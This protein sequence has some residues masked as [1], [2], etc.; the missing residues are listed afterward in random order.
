MVVSG[1]SCV[2]A[3][4]VVKTALPVA[5]AGQK[6]DGLSVTKPRKCFPLSL[7]TESIMKIM[8]KYLEIIRQGCEMQLWYL[9]CM[10][11]N[12]VA[13]IFCSPRWWCSLGRH[14]LPRYVLDVLAERMDASRD[15]LPLAHPG[16]RVLGRHLYTGMKQGWRRGVC[17]Q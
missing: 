17:V 8:K 13:S 15:S 4:C 14:H 11:Y 3:T 5:K 12:F 9:C 7:S 6:M 2:C 1:H 10:R 16:K